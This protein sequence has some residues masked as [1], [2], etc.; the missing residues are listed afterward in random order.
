MSF[1]FL[2]QC[3]RWLCVAGSEDVWVLVSGHIDTVSE[4]ENNWKIGETMN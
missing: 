4:L 2:L 1:L 3:V